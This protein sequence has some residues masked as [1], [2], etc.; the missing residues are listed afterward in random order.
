MTTHRRQA[1]VGRGFFNHNLFGFTLIEALVATAIISILVALALPAVVAARESMHRAECAANMRQLAIAVSSYL[2]VHN[3]YPSPV[4]V[5]TKRKGHRYFSLFSQILPQ[6]DNNL[7]YNSINFSTP[8]E[9]FYLDGSL[10]PEN[11]EN[12]T[13][14]STTINIFLC[15]SDNGLGSC[16]WTGPANYRVNLG[17]TWRSTG[18]EAKLGPFV[19]FRSTSPSSIRDG[20]SNTIGFSEKLRG[21]NVGTTYIPMRSALFPAHLLPDIELTLAR[22]KQQPLDPPPAYNLLG[23]S[24]LIGSLTHTCYNHTL[25]PNSRIPD[26][27]IRGFFPPA[28]LFP[29][30][31]LHPGGVN[32]AF[33]DGSVRFLRETMDVNT[34]QALGTA[35]GG[36]ISEY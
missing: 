16:P 14:L 19:A 17:T 22:C 10:S 27:L 25:T 11:E 9:D 33:L 31:S 3:A 34:W 26:C 23:L 35:A 36:E 5:G 13:A 8:L 1:S 15:P 24:W 12:R 20:L 4:G 6:L 32:A 18:P 21:G 7:S 30:R 2:N 29:P 28:G